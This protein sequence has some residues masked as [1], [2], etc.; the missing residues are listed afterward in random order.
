MNVS[1][2]VE[3]LSVAANYPDNPD[4]PDGRIW[5]MIGGESF[6]GENW[7]DTPLSV[8]GSFKTALA[9]LAAGGGEADSSFFDGPY[10]CRPPPAHRSPVRRSDTRHPAVPL[11]SAVDQHVYSSWTLYAYFV[12]LVENVEA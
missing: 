10:S 3:D 11:A 2:S 8:L 9:M 12:H 4:N 1:V 5:L 7:T 6:P